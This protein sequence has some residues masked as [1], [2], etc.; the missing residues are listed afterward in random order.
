[1]KNLKIK[2]ISEITDYQKGIKILLSKKFW[3]DFKFYYSSEQIIK[4]II[5]FTRRLKKI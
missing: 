3:E 4:R 5:K 1:M 2:I